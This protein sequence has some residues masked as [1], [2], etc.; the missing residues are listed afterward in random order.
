MSF[1]RLK[2]PRVNV[3]PAWYCACEI[4]NL[5]FVVDVGALAVRPV[6]T[7]ALGACAGNT[8]D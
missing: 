3:D 5:V 2:K 4:S 1:I 7:F 6:L 8:S